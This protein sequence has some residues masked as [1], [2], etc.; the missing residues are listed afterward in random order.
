MELL[1]EDISTLIKVSF[2]DHY[3]T[4]ILAKPTNCAGDLDLP[5]LPR[6]KSNFV[7]LENQ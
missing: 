1:V 3:F 4:L 7:G 6:Q 5:P 2:K